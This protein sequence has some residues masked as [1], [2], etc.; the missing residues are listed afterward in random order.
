[1][2]QMRKS[3][4]VGG[5]PGFPLCLAERQFVRRDDAH[6]AVAGGDEDQFGAA[7]DDA[8]SEGF[9][10]WSARPIHLGGLAM[11]TAPGRAR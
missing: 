10:A 11:Q 6:A 9:L 8:D 4:V 1:M 5:Q 7:A 2:R 3:L